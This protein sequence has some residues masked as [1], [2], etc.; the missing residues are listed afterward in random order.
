VT[1]V[2]TQDDIT[3]AQHKV[4]DVIRQL[5]ASTYINTSHAMLLSQR[6]AAKMLRPRAQPER[7]LYDII[8]NH[9]IRAE[10]I[11]P[12][13]MELC[14]KVLVKSELNPIDKIE[15][16]NL[17][18][19]LSDKSKHMT[20]QE[21]DLYLSLF[22]DDKK[23]YHL[24]SELL[25][26]SGLGSKIRIET[27]NSQIT[28]VEM[29]EGYHFNVTTKLHVKKSWQ[30][31]DVRCVCIDGIIEEVTEIHRLLSK[32]S[33]SDSN[34][35]APPIALFCRGYSNDVLNTIS[36]NFNRNTLNLIPF[37]VP[38]DFE[39]LNTLADIAIIS[40]S[41]VI[42]SEKGQL[43]SSL[44]LEN[45]PLVE[46]IHFAP[47]TANIVLVNSKT[48][49]AVNTQYKKLLELTK[50]SEQFKVDLYEKR[51]KSLSANYIVIRMPDTSQLE[52]KTAQFDATLRSISLL[53]KFGLISFEELDMTPEQKYRLAPFGKFAISACVLAAIRHAYDA[54]ESLKSLGVMLFK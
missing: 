32:Y 30:F 11:A 8:M 45:I 3:L 2:F 12:G 31:K 9:A 46:S 14:L 49:L 24:I 19:F 13:G 51:L 26:Y 41:E 20:S 38:F 48:K 44:D 10:N 47:L 43:I 34:I 50:K 52:I 39:G 53:T 27:T 21:V 25:K 1:T 33:K 17:V 16:S 15:F 54:Q 40:G 4:F 7:A 42:S 18:S 37:E 36:H 23:D 29:I 22:F 6:S 28:S 5:L 35:Q